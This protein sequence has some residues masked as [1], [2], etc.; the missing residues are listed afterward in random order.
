[1]I[2]FTVFGEAR[3]QGSTRA[4]IPKGWTRPII[5]SANPK[6]KPWRQEVSATALSVMKKERRKMFPRKIP[7]RVMVDF[8]FLK[9][10]SARKDE[11]HKVT[12]PDCDKLSRSILD[13]LEGIVYEHDAQV[14]QCW[15]NKFF[16]S[17]ARAE[18][19]VTEIG[20]GR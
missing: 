12:K 7:V 10:K 14:S 3:S 18:I 15:V 19:R 9:P 6:L 1:M 16:G 13:S 5:T 4:F 2:R 8:F 11:V 20:N 17:P